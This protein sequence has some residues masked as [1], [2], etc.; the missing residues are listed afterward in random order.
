MAPYREL[1]HACARGGTYKYFLDK[2]DVVAVW[3]RLEERYG[4]IHRNESFKTMEIEGDRLI[5]RATLL[6]NPITVFRKRL[7]GKP[8]IEEL[9]A[10]VGYPGADEFAG[11]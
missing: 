1:V 7:C 11:S 8:D 10:L 6:M 4:A 9:H 2:D 5:L 3:R